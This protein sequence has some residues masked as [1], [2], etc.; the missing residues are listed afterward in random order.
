VGACVAIKEAFQ[1]PSEG[2]VNQGTKVRDLVQENA[3]TR[4][5]KAR[6]NPEVGYSKKIVVFVC[7]WKAGWVGIVSSHNRAKTVCNYPRK[8]SHE[9]QSSLG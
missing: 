3:A 5:M 1:N 4:C 9:A 8:C 7:Q 2:M 6:C